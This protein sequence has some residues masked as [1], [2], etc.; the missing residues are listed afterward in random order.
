MHVDEQAFDDDGGRH[1]AGGPVDWIDDGQALGGGE[2]EQTIGCPAAAWLKSAGTILGF[3]TFSFAIAEAV[4][5][6]GIAVRATIQ[7]RLA[8]AKYAAMRS[9]PEVA[10]SI[11]HDM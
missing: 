1:A 10:G 2:P 4:D 11:V 6:F 9:H 8:G 7:V 5:G 3:K